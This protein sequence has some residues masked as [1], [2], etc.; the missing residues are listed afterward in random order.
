MKNYSRRNFFGKLMALPAGL[1]LTNYQAFSGSA[2]VRNQVK[3]TAIKAM[4]LDFL[5]DACLIKIETDSGLVGYGEAGVNST[6]ARGQLQYITR[7]ATGLIGGDPLSIERH[8]FRLSAPQNPIRISM[9]VI[10]GIDIALWD[11]SSKILDTPIYKLLGGPFRDG[12]PMYSH[13][14]AL[15]DMMDPGSCREWAAYIKAQPEGFTLFKGGPPFNVQRPFHPTISSSELRMLK[16]GFINIRDA[17][18]DSVDIAL[19]CTGQF[20]TPSSIA[21]ANT[22]ED[23]NISFIEDPL[24]ATYSEGWAALKRGTR[25]PVLTGEK[26]DTVKEFK[27]FLDGQVVD[28]IHPDISYAGGITGLM[29]IADYAS[30]TR[31]PVATH[32]AGTLIRTYASAHFSMAIDNFYK[33]ESRLGRPEHMYEQMATEAPVIRKAILQVPDKPGLGF[34][35][36]ESFL[37]KHLPKDEQ[38]WG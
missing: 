14:T 21:M 10:S 15:K 25:V 1:W 29:K 8:F 4:N 18:G 35:I 38:W 17:V 37:R 26:L 11:L 6:I 22:L 27:P 12:C 7:E 33:S 2:A 5:G 23:V 34:T 30:I 31:T 36:D 13:T 19:H 24:N 28:I 32:N 20:D 16:Q 9:G 3:I